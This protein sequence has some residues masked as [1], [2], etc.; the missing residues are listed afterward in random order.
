MT[1]IKD[2][3]QI[4]FKDFTD[5]WEQHKLGELTTYR[6]GAGHEEKQSESGKYELINLNSISI[7]GGLKPSGK[8]IDEEIETLLKDDLVMVLSDVGHGDLLGRVAIIPENNRF[9]LNQRVA[10]L[11]NNSSVDIKYLF[12]YINAHQ[13]YFKKQGAGSSQLN[14]SRGSVENFEVLLP[15]KDEQK[16]IGKYLSSIDHLITL[17]QRKYDKLTKI[18]KSM[19]DKMFPK[20]GSN[21]PEIRFK[22][23]TE[24]WEQRKLGDVVAK[25]TGGCSIAPDD[26]VEDGCKTIP[27][28][29]VNNSGVADLSGCKFVS[30]AFFERNISSTVSTGNL[31][32]SLRDL[33]PTAPNMGRIVRIAGNKE[34]Y[35]MPQGVYK[36][37]LNDG[38]DEDFVISYS[39]GNSFRQIISSE[40]NGSTQVH[41]RNGEFLNID[42]PLPN[43]YEQEKIGQCFKRL[44]NLITL[45]QRELEKMKNLKK[46]F[47]EKMFI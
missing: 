14:L 27:K 28:G 44:D 43:Q 15:H 29:A 30:P 41:I 21:V 6:N 10:L 5:A 2:K 11:R 31:V 34:D 36:I 38:V 19:L 9:V 13:I 33:V 17:H 18:K 23:F 32:T 46:A 37:E 20:N 26:Y 35:L 22:G 47:L 25:L 39:N 1:K 40:K 8:F 4:R 45:H 24:A 16:K 7:D 12:S 42:I 3:P